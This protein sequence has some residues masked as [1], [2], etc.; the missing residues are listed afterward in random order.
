MERIEELNLANAVATRLIKEA[1]PEGVEISEE[2]CTAIARASSS[3]GIYLAATCTVLAHN[4]NHDTINYMDVY[5]A[6]AKMELD[7][8]LPLS[9]DLEIDE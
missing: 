2:A 6:L 3:F 1:L 5:E 7:Y 8:V 9:Q 4:R